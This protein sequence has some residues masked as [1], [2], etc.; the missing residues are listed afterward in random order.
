LPK[1]AMQLAML[2]GVSEILA[3]HSSLPPSP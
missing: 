3:G 1:R 2:Y